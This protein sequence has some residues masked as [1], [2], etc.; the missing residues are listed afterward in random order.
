MQRNKKK[1]LNIAVV[2]LAALYPQATDINELW[3]NILTAKDLL[4]DIPPAHWL[5]EDYY[6]PNPQAPDKTYCKRGAFL[7]P[8]PFD[9]FEFKIPPSIV[10]STD[11]SQLLTLLVTKKLLQDLCQNQS[12]QHLD[13]SRTSIILGTT[14]AQELMLN[15]ARLDK[16]IWLEAMRQHCV[17]EDI[18]QKVCDTIASLY[19]PWTESTFPG[20]LGNVI[21]GRAANYFNVGGTNCI[22]DAACA[23][24]L[25]A[26]SMS[27]NELILD[28]SDLV[29]VGGVDT[30]Q[31]IAMYMCFSKTPALSRTGDC[32]PFADNADGTM[33]G[34]G[35]G[36][37]ALKR[38]ADAERDGDPIY[39]VIQGVGTSSDGRGKSVHV[40]VAEGQAAA[41]KRAY[42]QAGY[43][44]STV[45]LI[46]AHG[47]ATT[48]GDVAEFAGLKQVFEDSDSE[49]NLTK[50]W[51][52]LG[53]IKS[54]IGHTKGA[55]GAAGLIKAILALHHKTLPPTIK[56]N[57]PNPKLNIEDSPFYLN[58]KTRPWISPPN[59]PRRAGVSSFGFGGANFHVTVEEY[60]DSKH[61]HALLRTLP[62]ELL[63]LAAKDRNGLIQQ[64]E[65]LKEKAQTDK[66]Y[67]LAYYSQHQQ[68][69]E[70]DT[71][72]LAMV[73]TANNYVEKIQQAINILK[74]KHI[75]CPE[76]IFLTENVDDANQSSKSSKSDPQLAMLFP[77]QGSQYLNMGSDIAIHFPQARTIFE[78]AAMHTFNTEIRLDSVIFPP[79]TFDT[80][81]LNQQ[82][83]LL[84]ETQWCQPALAATSMALFSLLTTI[85]ISADAY[86]GHSFGEISAL[87]AAGWCDTNTLLMIARKRGELMAE[88]SQQHSG[89]MLAILHSAAE[90][91]ALLNEINSP[92]QVA[93]YN[94]PQQLV[95]SGDIAAI[96]QLEKHL[97]ARKWSYQR[98]P[99]ATA[100]HS[101]IVVSACQPFNL[102][103]QQQSLKNPTDTVY[104]NRHG[105]PFDN[106]QLA[107][108]N[109]QV[110]RQL[111]EPVQFMQQIEAMY[112]DGIR[113]FVEVGPG[114]VLK[115][116]IEQCLSHYPDRDYVVIA[117]DDKG[118]NGVTQFWK[119]IG[120]LFVQ[121]I[122]INFKPLWQ[123]YLPFNKYNQPG[124][125]S[126]TTLMIQGC[127]YDKQ[128]PSKNGA[129]G[130]TKPILKTEPTQPFVHEESVMKNTIDPNLMPNAAAQSFSQS[131]TVAHMNN[132][133]SHPTTAVASTIHYNAGFAQEALVNFEYQIVQA[134]TAYQRA[135]A[136]SHIAFL[137]TAERILGLLSQQPHYPAASATATSHLPSFSASAVVNTPKA[138]YLPPIPA[139]AQTMSPPKQPTL[140]EPVYHQSVA[141]QH[142][143]S[144]NNLTNTPPP[145]AFA[146]APAQPVPSTISANMNTAPIAPVM[147]APRIPVSNVNTATIPATPAPA[148]ATATVQQPI[149]PAAPVTHTAPTTPAQSHK[150]SL[151]DIILAI[152]ADKTGYPIEMLN[153]QM[154]LEADL[155]ID[156]IKRVEI[157]SA[158]Q[159]EIPN[160]PEID[161]MEMSTL[162]TLEEIANYFKK[163]V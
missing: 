51:C 89:T 105:Q 55:A 44:P 61:R 36:L 82:K 10:P 47:T 68:F 27:V 63:V 134:H 110:A 19:T 50:S 91:L 67:E 78:Q 152:V 126:K 1:P 132:N 86:A 128:Y 118:Q 120:Q 74:N 143:L 46:E 41:I 139:V 116:L 32:R 23:S 13:L 153:V 93:N 112:Q 158:A 7:D 2:G 77:G 124:L 76:D 155:G 22:V 106:K 114:S 115:K 99:V 18:A 15:S 92:L 133:H 11:T 54:Q 28:Q 156:S 107:A 6:D 4:R 53:S 109:N 103:L 70:S 162:K 113:I 87:A 163:I 161:A 101:N 88:A 59:Q 108:I 140:T 145:P 119:S 159:Q 35:V 96:E 71:T 72:R 42:Q 8:I 62:S 111:A 84:A 149:Q 26:L 39:A 154:D 30:M 129:A 130:K 148:Y 100:F 58:T 43:S 122:A 141:T 135:M 56:V 85:G 83:S 29:L 3:N 5:I 73:I 127:N 117:L 131:E 60:Q 25:S 57:K 64:C 49:T 48:A 94:S 150:G 123:D 151:E 95:L 104:S 98:L 90:V 137:Q 69:A 52:A 33:L 79:P 136:D 31:H 16:P 9:P 37:L 81:Q 14:G 66:F 157:L 102:W 40:P 121:K 21:A 160:L 147:T 34:E 138:P 45:E 80:T 146:P 144:A 97:T 12:Y 24:S 65:L 142:S 17:Q 75:P 125:L 20:A 38:L